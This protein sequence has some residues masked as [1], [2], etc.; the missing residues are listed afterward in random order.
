MANRRRH[1]KLPVIGRVKGQRG[2]I[3]VKPSEL[4]IDRQPDRV[5]VHND[6]ERRHVSVEGLKGL[7]LTLEQCMKN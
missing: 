6:S 2:R 3:V 5:V 7:S 4:H 1:N